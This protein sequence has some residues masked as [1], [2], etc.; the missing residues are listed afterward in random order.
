MSALNPIRQGLV[1]D[2]L[3]QWEKGSPKS[4]FCSQYL[5]GNYEMWNM[6]VLNHLHKDKCHP[7][8]V[9]RKFMCCFFITGELS[10]LLKDF[11]LGD[12]LGDHNLVGSFFLCFSTNHHSCFPSRNIVDACYVVPFTYCG[13]GR[14][15]WLSKQYSTSG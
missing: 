14:C 2:F 8:R 12:G 13:C 1:K 6:S 10:V 15:F 11:R 3:Q 9:C 4:P 5:E 7:L